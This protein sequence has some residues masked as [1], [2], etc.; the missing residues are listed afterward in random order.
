MFTIAAAVQSDGLTLG[1]VINGIPHD[2]PAMVVYA[3]VLVF[4]GF[5][6]LG[7]RTKSS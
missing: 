4:A 7:S 1:D 2:G 5:V 3:L 6:W